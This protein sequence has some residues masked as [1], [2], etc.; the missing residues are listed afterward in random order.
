M[1]GA[2]AV[3]YSHC[4][5]SRFRNLP[6]IDNKSSISF[7]IPTL[8]E[9]SHLPSTLAS[10]QKQ[11]GDHQIIIADARSKDATPAIAKSHD[12]DF[13]TSPQGRGIQ[14][15]AGATLARHNYLCFLHADTQLPAGASASIMQVLSDPSTI[16]GSFPLQF[17]QDKAL[18]RF[19]AACSRINHTLFT[20]GDQALF[21]RAQDY[22]TLGGYRNFPFLEDIEIQRRLRKF[23]RF[24]K[25]RLCVTTSARRFERIG[26]LRQQLRNIAIVA[27]YLLGLSPKTLSLYYR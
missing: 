3:R 14:L 17:D 1:Q 25:S 27:A 11:P 5:I 16:A 26:P 18:Y 9:E 24:K 13:I 4:Q 12:T 2:A 7:I 10:I 19:Y 23:G 15:N 8:N 20:Y 22:K 6:Q 21:L